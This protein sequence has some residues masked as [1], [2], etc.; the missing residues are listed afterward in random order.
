MSTA[1]NEARARERRLSRRFRW[2]GAA[3]V[4]AGFNLW[5]ESEAHGC[6]HYYIRSGAETEEDD[7]VRI[8]VSDHYAHGIRSAGGRWTRDF[9]VEVDADM[10]RKDVEGEVR[11]A[12]ASHTEYL[13]SE[14]FRE[15]CKRQARAAGCSTDEIAGLKK[16]KRGGQS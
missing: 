7:W 6:S 8:R 11:E 5:G 12:V 1:K 10:P 9:W 2:A 13:L 15:E 14:E 16:G 4:A 3:L